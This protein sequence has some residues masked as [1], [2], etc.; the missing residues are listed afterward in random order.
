VASHRGHAAECLLLAPDTVLQ[1]RYR[2]VRQ[3]SKGGMGTV[4]EALDERLDTVVALK[5]CHFD[6]PRLQKQF[7]REARL[8]A[9][10][11][12]PAMTKVIDHFSERDGQ[13]LVM[14]YIPGD[15]L[16][17]IFHATNH[18]FTSAE[19][20]KWADQLL[21]ALDYLHTQEPPIVHRDIKPQ[22]LKLTARGQIILLDFGLAK[23]FGGATSRV[24]DSGSIF[25]YTPN[26]AP[27][28]QIQGT[29]TD[30]RSD[31][32]SLAATLYHLMTGVTPPDALTRITAVANEQPDPLRP[33]SEVNRSVPAKIA[34]MLMQAMAQNRERRPATAAEMRKL[35]QAASSA[36]TRESS[37]EAETIPQEFPPE[38]STIPLP[39]DP[40]TTPAK[41][42]RRPSLF[43]SF[44]QG[45]NR[46]TWT[47]GAT[48]ALLLVGTVI[49]TLLF[50]RL[51][52][53]A[54]ASGDGS[55]LGS[56]L[57]V[58][59]VS[60]PGYAGGITANNGFKANKECIYWTK[61]HQSVEFLLLEDVEVR[62]I[63]LAKGGADGV[64]IVWSSVDFLANE[65]PG[66]IKDGVNVRTIMQVDWSRGGDAI[67]ADQS[68][69]SIED[70]KGKRVS[71]ALFTPSHWL[72]E[73]SLENSSLSDEDQSAIIKNAIGKTASPDARA[74]FVANKVDAAVLWE[75]DVTEALSKRPGAHILLS[76][77]IA[78]NL[79]AD[80]LVAREDFI[81]ANPQVVKA[82]IQGWMD[83]TEEANRRPDQVVKLLM[84]NEPL[85]MDLGDKATRDSLQ[86]VRWAG[87]ADNTTMFG[88]D[89]SE[90]LFDRLFKEA[91]RAWLRRGYISQAIPPEQARDLGFLKEIYA[92]SPVSGPAMALAPPNEDMKNRPGISTKPI[93]ILF[94]QGSNLLTEEAIKTIDDNVALLV[95]TYPNAYIRVEGNTDS[96]EKNLT[97][98]NLSKMRAQ[99]VVDYLVQR[100][101]LNPNRFIVVG[102]GPDKPR[103]SSATVEGRAKN[104][105]TDIIVI[106]AG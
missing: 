70:L 103:A 76:T 20:M 80:V 101:K 78:S 89:G 65:L 7:E 41:S 96:Q 56:P 86:T 81:K 12:H 59:I 43:F 98:I 58:G 79:I 48:L 40:A 19:A 93:D 77:Q 104:R 51:G 57:R 37:S 74:D 22:N 91:S 84:E 17:G 42:R 73:Y 1:N 69:K 83:G 87:L 32:Y 102:N 47:I 106:P 23:G 99:A 75:P 92:Q 6:D 34:D 62:N 105:R 55:L 26:Y 9:R 60:W 67:V 61:Y 72:L 13:F 8:L 54:G 68:I 35:L 16:L 27:L 31:L 82:F 3:L 5:E 21:D 39:A 4:Y 95:Q 94:V 38:A 15:D 66:F 24:T 46:W 18:P 30:A 11:R 71:L 100:Y 64:D 28:E 36:Q 50:L 25:G 52:R 45:P 63:A 90:P 2:V 33:A 53:L 14:E 88:L 10:L 44:T 49:P 97:N 85:Y 29:G